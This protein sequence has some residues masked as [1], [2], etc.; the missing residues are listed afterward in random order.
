MKI[1]DNEAYFNIMDKPAQKNIYRITIQSAAEMRRWT[2]SRST[3]PAPQIIYIKIKK[4][5]VAIVGKGKPA[6][7]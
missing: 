3:Q 1:G 2:G 4:L 5:K 7:P 6:V